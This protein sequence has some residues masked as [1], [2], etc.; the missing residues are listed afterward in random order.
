MS[1]NV[2]GTFDLRSNKDRL[3]GGCSNLIPGDQGPAHLDIVRPGDL[4]DLFLLN[5]TMVE[6]GIKGTSFLFLTRI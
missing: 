3:N 2:P 4:Y 1:F 6:P 5:R